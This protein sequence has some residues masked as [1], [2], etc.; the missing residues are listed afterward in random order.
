M[1]EEFDKVKIR[2]TDIIG[3]VIDMH[4][5]NGKAWCF[6]DSATKGEPGVYGYCPDWDLFY[7]TADDLEK[8]D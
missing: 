6:I 5:A 1:I 4:M 8:I 7:C 2:G 3:I